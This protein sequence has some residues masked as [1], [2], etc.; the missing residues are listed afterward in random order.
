M[1]CSSARSTEEYCRIFDLTCRIPHSIV[2]DAL[3]SDDLICLNISELTEIIRRIEQILKTD[4][5]VSSVP[6]RICIPSFG[7]PQWGDLTSQVGLKALLER[8]ALR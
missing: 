4:D 1:T 8:L 7:S 6:I 3:Q 2:D 5:Q